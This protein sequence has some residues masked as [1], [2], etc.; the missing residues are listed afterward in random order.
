MAME[1]C[2]KTKGRK[3]WG[4]KDLIKF[5]ISVSAPAASLSSHIIA[6]IMRSVCPRASPSHRPLTRQPVRRISSSVIVPLIIWCYLTVSI[7]YHHLSITCQ[8]PVNHLSSHVS[9]LSSHVN[10]LSSHVNHLSSPWSSIHLYGLN[11][12]QQNLGGLSWT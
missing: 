10:H 8:S 3:S 2:A 7:T 11:R 4:K 12:R 1:W 6:L 5:I 9:H